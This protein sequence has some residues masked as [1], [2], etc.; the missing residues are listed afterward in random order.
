MV[1]TIDLINPDIGS[2]G[3][4]TITMINN[5]SGSN[6][7][8]KQNVTTLEELQK[9]K[10][11]VTIISKRNN[12]F[13]ININCASGTVTG[14]LIHNVPK[15][16][17]VYIETVNI[18]F[19]YTDPTGTSL[20]ILTQDNGGANQ[21]LLTY[22]QGNNSVPGV[23]VDNKIFPTPI[24]LKEGKELIYTSHMADNVSILVTGWTEDASNQ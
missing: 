24:P 7:V 15:G 6:V 10:D 4:K 19:T 8:Y 14:D 9:T 5:E 22:I 13:Y 16:K 1:K 2:I 20:Q 17:I 21:V 12:F 3:K 18:S 23:V 11:I